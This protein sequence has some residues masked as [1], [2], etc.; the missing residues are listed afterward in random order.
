MPINY[1][2][3]QN[4]LSNNPDDYLAKAAANG[5]ADLDRV[6]DR[7]MADGSTVTRADALSALESFF[8][9][10]TNLLLEGVNV[11][12]PIANFRVGVKGVFDGPN[13]SFTPERHQVN[14][15]ASAGKRLRQEFQQKAQLRKQESGIPSPNLET[16]L[17]INSQTRN[18][19]LTPGG[20]GQLTG[21]RLKFDAADPRQGIFFLAADGT[22]TRVAIIGQIKPSSLMFVVPDT[23]TTGHYTVEVRAV[24][25]R[26]T[27]LRS[28]RLPTPL[29]AP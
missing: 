12:T 25:P 17:D 2:L 29:T 5:T 8:T 4:N 24:L 16:Y 19:T 26:T 21:Y 13:D 11:T 1:S 23:L 14:P 20:M 10:V 6:I 3:Y 28:G 9:A 22:E 27:A 18:A 7:M 15:T